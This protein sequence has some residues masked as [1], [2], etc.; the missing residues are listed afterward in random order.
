MLHTRVFVETACDDHGR[1]G[2]VVSI[3]PSTVGVH[4][5]GDP[6]PKAFG[7]GRIRYRGELLMKNVIATKGPYQGQ[8]G[9]VSFVKDE[10]MA[11]MLDHAQG[12]KLIPFSALR[13]YRVPARA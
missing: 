6:Q 5:D 9:F 8:T 10:A 1:P 7:P 2:T 4:L 12:I 3:N 13:H 11:V